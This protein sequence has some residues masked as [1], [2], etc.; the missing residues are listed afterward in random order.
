PA[1]NART[2]TRASGDTIRNSACQVEPL[3]RKLC[4]VYPN[5]VPESAESVAQRCCVE[6][7]QPRVRVSPIDHEPLSALLRRVEHDV[8]EQLFHDA[9]Q[10]ARP[11]LLLHRVLDDRLQSLLLQLQIDAVQRQGF[12]VL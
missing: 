9:A 1:A 10:G 3:A 4:I 8:G 2:C 5:Q 6:L 12:A 11:E 7:L